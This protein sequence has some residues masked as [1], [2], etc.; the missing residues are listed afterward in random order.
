[1]LVRVLA[2]LSLCLLGLFV[3][4]A[5]FHSNFPNL[6]VPDFT[7]LLVV[8][9]GL[10]YQNI[11]GILLSFLLGLILDFASALYLGPHAAGCV[12]V[13]CITGVIAKRVFAEKTFAFVSITFW[14]CL[15]KSAVYTL[16]LIV[17]VSGD[18][19]NLG[20]LKV[21]L[22]EALMTAFVAPFV[23]KLF[24]RRQSKNRFSNVLSLGSSRKV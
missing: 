22:L 23:F 17:Y 6:V 3:Q 12:F 15:I 2:F 5:V 8:Y 4:G 19:L 9:I 11:K 20:S 18:L 24:L 10:H 21:I 1:M 16:L 14:A 13:F 7:V